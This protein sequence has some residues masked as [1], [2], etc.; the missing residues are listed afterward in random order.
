MVHK[1]LVLVGFAFATLALTGHAEACS[2][3]SFDSPP[4][5]ESYWKYEVAFVGHIVEAGRQGGDAKVRIDRALKGVSLGEV[6]VR[7]ED[8]GIGCGYPFKKGKDYVVF[9]TRNGEGEIEI[10]GCSRDIWE[11]GRPL[12][13]DAL[14]FIDTLRKPAMGGWIYGEVSLLGRAFNHDDADEKSRGVDG[15]TV[16]LEGAGIQRRTTTVN[17]RFEFVGMPTGKY[18]VSMQMPQGLPAALTLRVPEGTTFDDYLTLPPVAGYS[19][20]ITIGHDRACGYAPFGAALDGRI[21]GSVLGPE[22]SPAKNVEV[23]AVPAEIDTRRE[24]YFSSA[25][26]TT[27]ER[28]KYEISGLFPGRYVVGVN[29]R[30][31]VTKRTPH[32]IVIFKDAAGRDDVDVGPGEYVELPSL[33]LPAQS[34][35]RRLAGIVER[36]DG[37]SVGRAFVTVRE[38][39]RTELGSDVAFMRADEGGR[40]SVD[41]FEGRTYLIIAEQQDPRRWNSD[42]GEEYPPLA[43]ATVRLTVK[44]DRDGVRLL[45]TP[46]ERQLDPLE[47]ATT[48]CRSMPAGFAVQR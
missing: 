30:D 48:R 9:A 33:R 35:M 45:L 44:G 7:N 16:L 13:E 18:D 4:A 36:S 29:L 39:D 1:I 20:T 23:E 46:V 11:L 32:P 38:A 17:G 6:T 43:T 21:A 40:F 2:C 22:G 41:V 26:V 37:L 8:A 31:V 47:P 14:R 34:T 24:E 12:S 3:G 42:T 10:A 28:G 25:T 19:R 5:C 15:A 27:D